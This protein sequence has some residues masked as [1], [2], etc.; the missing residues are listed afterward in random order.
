MTQH[1]QAGLVIDTMSGQIMG[2]LPSAIP[3][4]LRRPLSCPSRTILMPASYEHSYD[5]QAVVLLS[6]SLRPNT[7]LIVSLTS[8]ASGRDC[9]GERSSAVLSDL[10]W[11][12]GAQCV[13]LRATGQV[14]NCC[15]YIASSEVVAHASSGFVGRGPRG[16]TAGRASEQ[17][18]GWAASERLSCR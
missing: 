6:I 13:D 12:P 5:S 15:G 10:V 8:G 18:G 9:E 14:R 16:L 7:N 2:L 11:P 4:S 1:H 3:L 17:A